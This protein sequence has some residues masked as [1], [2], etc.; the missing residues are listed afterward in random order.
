MSA[1]RSVADPFAKGFTWS[2]SRLKNFETCPKRHYHIDMKRD[3]YEEPSEAVLWGN[4]LHDALAHAIGTDDNHLRHPRDKID[5]KP[6]PPD[7]ARFQPWVARLHAARGGGGKVYVEQGLAVTRDFKP[8]GWFDHNVWFRAKVDAIVLTADERV[9]AGFDWKTGKRVEDSP[10]LMMAAI[11]IMAHYPKVEA[12]RTEFVWLKEMRDDAPF[13]CT[14][15]VSFRR[16]DMAAMWN[17]LAPR[18]S[19][20]ERAY[21]ERSYPARPSGLCRRWCPVST[22]EHHGR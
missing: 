5:L 11:T 12:V 20:L 9:A 15:R 3:V 19:L 16:G 1:P 10:Q 17:G 7:Y 4:A 6:L 8:T 21:E 14:D 13:D 18:V 22:C 2:Y